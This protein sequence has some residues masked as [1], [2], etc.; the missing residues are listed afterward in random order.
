MAVREPELVP[1]IEK[2]NVE[3]I[4]IVVARVLNRDIMV[5]HDGR[6]VGCVKPDINKQKCNQSNDG[7]N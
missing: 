7:D 3:Q 6:L 1:R 2:S 5:Y 4:A